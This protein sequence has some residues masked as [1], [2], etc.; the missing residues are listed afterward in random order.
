M[1]YS[2]YLDWASLGLV[3][4]AAINIGLVGLG[5]IAGF[6][7]NLLEAVFK[8]LGDTFLNLFYLLIGFA[9]VYQVYFGYQFYG[10]R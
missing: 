8:P 1:N 6:D 10:N 4:L 5:N 2:N 3:V 7:F 9:G